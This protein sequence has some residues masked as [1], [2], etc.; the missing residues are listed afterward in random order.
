[1]E[2]AREES[3][4]ARSG[5]SRGAIRCRLDFFAR[6]IF[7]FSLPPVLLSSRL[8]YPFSLPVGT[9][10]P[11][12]VGAF[13]SLQYVLSACTPPVSVPLVA[14]CLLPLHQ[15]VT[16]QAGDAWRRIG[17]HGFMLHSSSVTL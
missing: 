3:K 8:D 15:E 14:L 1:M 12:R 10:V 4:Q 11:V 16:P 5:R 2:T 17:F 13:A 6:I 7:I 9:F